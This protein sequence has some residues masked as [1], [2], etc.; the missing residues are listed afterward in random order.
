MPIETKSINPKYNLEDRLTKFSEDIVIF[1]KRISRDMVTDVLVKQLVRSATS[2]GANYM[3]ADVASSKKDFIN[4][5]NICRK[6]SKETSYWLRL[7]AKT[8]PSIKEECR[9]FWSE[10]HEFLL[11]FSKI[12][13]NHRKNNIQ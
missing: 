7:L 5:I 11:I 1:L 4:K 10:S 13:L 12:V 9:K 2:I 3:E 8:N 6:E